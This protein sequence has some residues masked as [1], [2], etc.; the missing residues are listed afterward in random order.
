MT[1]LQNF[2]QL[3]H[4]RFTNQIV[5][6]SFIHVLSDTHIKLTLLDWSIG[7]VK[8][9]EKA[10]YLFPD[11][12]PLGNSLHLLLV[13]QSERCVEVRFT[14]LNKKTCKFDSPMYQYRV[15]SFPQNEISEMTLEQFIM[16]QGLN[17]HNYTSLNLQ[18]FLLFHLHLSLLNRIVK[19]MLCSGL[20]WI[21]F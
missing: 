3:V 6:F 18:C 11:A 10:N 20:L 13:S 7:G 16:K 1:K 17:V 21:Y 15:F 9:I 5:V 14:Q 2:M 8:W 19:Y 12:Y 4:Q